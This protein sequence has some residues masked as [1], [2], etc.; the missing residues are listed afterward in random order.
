M[1][2]ACTD[3]YPAAAMMSVS[4]RTL[5]VLLVLVLA[6]HST[7]A[8]VEAAGTACSEVTQEAPDRDPDAVPASSGHACHAAAH[9]V[10]PPACGIALDLSA[11]QAQGD[12][13]GYAVITFESMPPTPPPTV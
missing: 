11:G 9:V 6:V 1:D 7:A 5:L 10:A 3:D 13:Y 12:D 4:V 2:G 8:G